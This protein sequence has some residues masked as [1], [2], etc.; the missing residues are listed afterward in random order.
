MSSGIFILI[1]LIPINYTSFSYDIPE[2]LA[3][4][5]T[6]SALAITGLSIIFPLRDTTPEPRFSASLAASIIFIA[7]SI[8]F[9]V[10]SKTLCN[11][12]ICLGFIKDFPS[13]P[14]CFINVASLIKP[15]SLFTSE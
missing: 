4:I 1:L 6:L 14:S 2:A 3:S 11:K 10:G 13:K 9:S 12:S 7:L 5:R 15:S 8:S